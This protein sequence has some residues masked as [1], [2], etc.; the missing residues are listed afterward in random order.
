MNACMQFNTILIY[1]KPT[2]RVR[3]FEILTSMIT[4]LGISKKRACRNNEKS[5]IKKPHPINA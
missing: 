4:C 1:Q 2:E 3:L 5:E